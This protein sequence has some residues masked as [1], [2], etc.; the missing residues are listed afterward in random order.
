MPFRCKSCGEIHNDDALGFSFRAPAYF[1]GVSPTLQATSILTGDQCIVGD[2]FFVAG[3]LEV[4][5]IGTNK[6][7]GWTAWVSLSEKNFK[8]M[9]ELWATPG[10][11]S[12]PAYFGWFSNSLPEYLETLNLKVSLHTRP[13]GVRPL[14]ELEPTSHPLAV[15]QRGGVSSARAQELAEKLRHSVQDVLPMDST[16]SS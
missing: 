1:E 15:E 14:I 6:F 11:E 9:A 5:I 10:R 13:V 2:H 16:A 4:P 7:F 3:C 12:E 8:R